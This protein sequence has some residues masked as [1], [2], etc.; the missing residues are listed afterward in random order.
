MTREKLIYA[1]ADWIDPNRPSGL[2]A[3]ALATT[4]VDM[5]RNSEPNEAASLDA[6]L[7]SVCDLTNHAR[8]D[9]LSARERLE[10]TLTKEGKH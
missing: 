10:S 5:T 3:H 2:A 7:A 9:A 4:F 6:L 8:Q 1:L